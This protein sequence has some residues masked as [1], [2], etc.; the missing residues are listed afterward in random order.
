MDDSELVP[1]FE[2][3]PLLLQMIIAQREARIDALLQ[4]RP[5]SD[6]RL[7]FEALLPPMV[8]QRL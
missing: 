1:V 7:D 3:M 5:K 2:P 8:G 4:P 6:A